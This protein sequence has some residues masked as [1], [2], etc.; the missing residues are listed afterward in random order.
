MCI[1]R[2]KQWFYYRESKLREKSKPAAAPPPVKKPRK[3]VRLTQAQA[4]SVQYCKKGSALHTELYDAWNLY[5]A[6]DEAMVIKYKHL[7][8]RRKTKVPFVTFQQAI[9]TERLTDATEEEKAALDLFI[10]KRFE[11]DVEVR[12]RPWQALKIDDSQLEADLE[13][14]YLEE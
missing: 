10:E 9:I 5:V 14:Q 3:V 11:R 6:G 8:T 1:Q 12:E 7:F 13:K 4:Y 2:I